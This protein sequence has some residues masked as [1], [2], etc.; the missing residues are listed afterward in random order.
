MKVYAAV[1]RVVTQRTG[2]TGQATA[3]EN[4]TAVK[5]TIL[6]NRVYL[7]YRGMEGRI[8]SIGRQTGPRTGHVERSGV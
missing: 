3:A 2:V 4:I 7:E 6:Y 5:I 1:I 8:I